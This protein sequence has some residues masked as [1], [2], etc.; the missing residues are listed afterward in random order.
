[1]GLESSELLDEEG[2]QV[3]TQ[4]I[5]GFGSLIKDFGLHP[6]SSGKLL[7]EEGLLDMCEDG[8]E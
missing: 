5:Q 6:K 2:G 7:K 4:T 1:M 3:G 8:I